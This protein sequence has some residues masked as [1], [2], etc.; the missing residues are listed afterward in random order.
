M[1]FS[2][3]IT[4][5]YQRVTN[6]ISYHVIII[7]FI[8]ISH[9]SYPLVIKRRHRRN[10]WTAIMIFPWTPPLLLGM[11]NCHCWSIPLFEISRQSQSGWWFEPLWKI[12]VTIGMI[13]PNIWENKKVP[14]H[15]PATS[16][17]ELWGARSAAPSASIS[18]RDHPAD[19]LGKNSPGTQRPLRGWDLHASGI[20]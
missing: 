1:G 13:I 2:A 6:Y 9:P 16:P 19:V 3:T 4:F 18:P 8:V 10:V 15:P 5:D 20:V 7:A 14:N 12:L 17:S 11:F